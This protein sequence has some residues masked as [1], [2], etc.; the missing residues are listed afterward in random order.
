[1]ILANVLLYWN[2][3]EYGAAVEFAEGRYVLEMQVPGDS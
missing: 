3:T 1:M 2:G